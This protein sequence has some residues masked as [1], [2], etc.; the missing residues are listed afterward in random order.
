MSN[1]SF[2]KA[3]PFVFSL[4]ALYFFSSCQQTAEKGTFGYDLEFF[5]SKKATLVLTAEG[6]KGQ[7]LLAPGYQGRVMTS[8]SQ[9]KEGKS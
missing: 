6:G 4:F 8:T 9:G 7:V 1:K 2:W 5:K 3:R